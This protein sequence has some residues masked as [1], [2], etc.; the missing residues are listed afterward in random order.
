MIHVV[1][2]FNSFQ[3]LWISKTSPQELLEPFLSQFLKISPSIL[4]KLNPSIFVFSFQQVSS[5]AWFKTVESQ[6]QNSV[7]DNMVFGV[8]CA[9]VFKQKKKTAGMFWLPHRHHHSTGNLPLDWNWFSMLVHEVLSGMV[10][11][12]KRRWLLSGGARNPSFLKKKPFK[13]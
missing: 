5:F 12:S 2:S 3:I 9:P 13:G 7:S 11:G 8:A 4:A 10:G 6:N 1:L